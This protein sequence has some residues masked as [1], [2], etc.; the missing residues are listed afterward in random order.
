MIIKKILCIA[1]LCAPFITLSQWTQDTYFDG[2][3]YDLLEHNNEL[4]IVGSFTKREFTTCYY[5]ASLYLNSFSNQTNNYLGGSLRQMAKS[6]FSLYVT[7]SIFI[8]S[9]TG[10][11]KKSGFGWYDEG[12]LSSGHTGIYANGNTLYV[13]DDLGVVR[14]RVGNGPFSTY[15]A[16]ADGTSNYVMAITEFDGNLVVGGLFTYSSFTDSY[17]ISKWVNNDW[18]TLDDGTDDAILAMI[19]YKSEL[20]AAGIFENAGN[21]P[22]KFIAKWNGTSWS[23]VGGSVTG[24]GL[25][26]IRDL[27]VY[28][29]LLFVAGDFDEIGNV[30]ATD[31]AYWDGSS[32]HSLNFVNDADYAS[33]I[34]TYN[35]K[36]YVG[37]SDLTNAPLYSRSLSFIDVNEFSSIQKLNIYPNPTNSYVQFDVIDSVDPIIVQTEIYSIDGSLVYSAMSNLSAISNEMISVKDWVKGMY[38]VQ[39]SDSKNGTLVHQEKLIVQ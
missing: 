15:P 38:Y 35:N 23:D 8:N 5:S 19:V 25:N 12:S 7:G 18:Y 24:S 20:Y 2:P 6:G 37:T 28:D 22:A 9:N 26:G 27:F 17:N 33:S 30:P 16:L 36:L 1:L 11:F 21:S 29:G 32:W 10:L 31:I 4:Q 34:T 14:K 3:I 39:I 13:G